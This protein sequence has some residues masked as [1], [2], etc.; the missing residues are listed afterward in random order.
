MEVRNRSSLAGALILITLGAW[1]LAV[2]LSPQVRAFAYGGETWPLQIVGIGALMLL[3]A[4]LTFTPGWAV[5]ACIV[6]GLGGLLYWQNATDNWASWAYAWTLIPGF[7]G[8]GIILAGLLE[9]KPRGALIG[10]GWT[11]FSS[12][13]LFGIFG[14]FLGGLSLVGQLWPLLLIVVGVILLGQAFLRSRRT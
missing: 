6:G 7:V 1:F 11:I 5:P 14:S 8:V 10:G 2:E 13:L 12:L 3:V 4:L 9:G